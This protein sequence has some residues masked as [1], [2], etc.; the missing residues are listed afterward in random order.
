MLSVILT[1]LSKEF[2]DLIT[3]MWILLPCGDETGLSKTIRL[4]QDEMKPCII[5]SAPP[6]E[7]SGCSVT[8]PS[9]QVS[10]I[11]A[12]INYKDGVFFLT[13]LRSEHGTW[14]T[15][16]EGKRYRVPPNYPARIHPTN[17]IEFGSTKASFRIKVTRSVP[18]ISEKKGEQILVKV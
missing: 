6:E 12:R 13:D 16:I 1:I 15:D 2:L 14:I 4:N 11:H 18:R 8:I 7:F 5:G 10:E 3:L 17:V 9:P